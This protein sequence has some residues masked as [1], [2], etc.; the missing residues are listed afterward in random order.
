MKEIKETTP[1]TPTVTTQEG[2]KKLPKGTER[3]GAVVKAYL[4]KRAGEDEFFK[5][6]YETVNCPIEDILA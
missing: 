3:F 4:D 5:A 6:K 1:Q 2:K